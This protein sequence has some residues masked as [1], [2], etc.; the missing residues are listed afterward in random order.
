MAKQTSVK[1]PFEISELIEGF[2]ELRGVM[3]VSSKLSETKILLNGKNIY[4]ATNMFS[5]LT[6]CPHSNL[7]YFFALRISNTLAVISALS[8]A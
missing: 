2:G 8:L 7:I 3:I 1:Y 4:N 6:Q 5:Y